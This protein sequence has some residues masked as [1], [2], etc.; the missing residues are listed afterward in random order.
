MLPQRGTAPSRWWALRH[1]ALVPDIHG[2]APG[3]DA[4]AREVRDGLVAFDTYDFATQ[5]CTSQTFSSQSDGTVR[6][7]IGRFRY[8]WP[9]ECDL[10]AALAGLVL[11]TRVA[12]W[13]GRPFGSSST[14]HTSVWRKPQRGGQREGR[15]WPLCPAR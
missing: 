3:T 8:L 15:D 14:K 1:R 4:V 9:S 10:M 5:Q 12:S 7:D 11:E 2:T 13:D 6:H